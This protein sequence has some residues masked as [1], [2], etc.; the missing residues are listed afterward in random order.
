MNNQT[1]QKLY[2]FQVDQSVR[3]EE[4]NKDTIIG[5]ANEEHAF[6]LR[7]P[8]GVKRRL[9]GS[10]RREGKP[11]L[12]GPRVFAAA[13]ALTISKSGFRIQELIIDLEYPGYDKN[14][15]RFIKQ[16][17][18]ATFVDSAAIGKKSPAHYAAHGVYLKK[19]QVNLTATKREILQL[20][21]NDPRTVTPLDKSQTIR[22]P[23]RPSTSNIS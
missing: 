17:S 7:V 8:R 12:F 19:R 6:T 13:V 9:H 3:L 1:L 11:Q 15:I 16:F 20:L 2:R 21:K 23:R 14:S 5:L 4:L 22:S 10:F 18:P